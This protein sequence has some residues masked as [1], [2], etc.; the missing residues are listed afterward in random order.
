MLAVADVSSEVERV[1]VFCI[2]RSLVGDPWIVFLDEPTTGPDPEFCFRFRDYFRPTIA[3]G[4]TMA[5]TTRDLEEAREYCD[6]DVLD[7]TRRFVGHHFQAGGL[8]KN[9]IALVE[10][11]RPS[12]GGDGD[13]LP[14][15]TQ[16][17]GVCFGTR[18]DV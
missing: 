6:A 15:V 9:S 1:R 7:L 12:D 16:F 11:R 8:W 17:R 4:M 2:A 14:V 5:T 3:R 13:F 10:V 18:F